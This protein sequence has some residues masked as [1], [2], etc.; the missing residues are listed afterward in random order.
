MSTKVVIVA[1]SG[2]LKEVSVKNFDITIYKFLGVKRRFRQ[3]E[4]TKS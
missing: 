4:N 2:D 3:I 1:K